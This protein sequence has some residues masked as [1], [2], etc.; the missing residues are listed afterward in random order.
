MT[1]RGVFVVN[2][3]NSLKIAQ[4]LTKNRIY[5]DVVLDV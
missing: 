4:K 2:V 3:W 5:P 1:F